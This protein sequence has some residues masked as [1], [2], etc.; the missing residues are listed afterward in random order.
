MADRPKL[1]RIGRTYF[2]TRVISL[3]LQT[4]LGGRR[5]RK[6]V[7]CSL[8]PRRSQPH[9]CPIV[10]NF[11]LTVLKFSKSRRPTV[12]KQSLLKARANLLFSDFCPLVVVAS[13]AG[14]IESLEGLDFSTG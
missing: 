13:L 1:Y 11:G 7:A 12:L 5:A 4:R 14:E 6:N 8:Y 10:L 9:S 3:I 2:G